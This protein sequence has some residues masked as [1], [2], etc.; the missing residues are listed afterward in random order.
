MKK[1]IQLFVLF[2]LF[3]SKGINAQISI[4][5]ANMPLSGDTIGYSN[6]ATSSINYT[7]TGANMYWNYDSLKSQSKGM[8]NYL[9]ASKTPY[10]FY[11]T[12]A[13]EYG[14]KIA[15]S[16]G[17]GT[18]TFKNVFDFYKNSSASFETEGI[19]FE[20]S[21]FP[22]A[23]K[24]SDPDEIYTFPLSYL[25]HDSTTYRFTI[26]LGTTVYYGQHGYRINDVDGW[27]YIKTPYDDSVAC[28][29]LVS[30]TYGKDSIN[31]NGIGFN[32]PDVQRSYKWMSLTEKIPVLELDGT[33]TNNTF[34]PTQARYRDSV[35]YVAGIETHVSNTEVRVFPNPT[36]GDLYVYTNSPD[37]SIINLYNVT[38]VLVAS[39][40]TNGPVTTIATQ[41]LPKGSYYYSISNK[42]AG[43]VAT[44]KVIVMN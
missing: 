8:Y 21:G 26:A 12:S 34:V 17:T 35:S 22:L 32:F 1:S 4:T 39:Y 19:G 29:R 25:D 18:Y 30:T 33:Y 23:A 13:S 5:S 3:I 9:A 43:Q 42:K 41:N 7:V 37:V 44:G 28:I 36:S 15:D 38:G 27:G 31:Y 6:C 40:K 20:Y 11:Y 24:Y 16:I 10:A 14:L 2:S